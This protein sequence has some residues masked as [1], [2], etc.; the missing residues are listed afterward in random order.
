MGRR[1]HAGAHSKGWMH[2]MTAK[3]I[4]ALYEQCVIANYARTPI[5]FVRGEGSYLWDADGRRYIDLFPGWA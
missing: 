3:D 4:I 5:V 2:P 1:A